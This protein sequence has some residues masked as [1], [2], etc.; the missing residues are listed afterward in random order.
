V[1]NTLINFQKLSRRIYSWIQWHDNTV[2]YSHKQ[3]QLLQFSD[4][5]QQKR[6]EICSH[7]TRSLDSDYTRNKFAPPRTPLGAYSAPRNPWL[8]WREW[9]GKGKRRE[10]TKHPQINFWLRSFVNTGVLLDW[11]QSSG[12]YLAH[13]VT[14][15]HFLC[16]FNIQSF[17]GSNV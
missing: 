7:Q 12:S 8:R 9:E 17:D 16:Y 14:F 2:T 13:V 1:L 3:P 5:V 4:S 6:N 10:G 15:L 11:V